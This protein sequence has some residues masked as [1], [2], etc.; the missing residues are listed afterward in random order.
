MTK[1]R[2]RWCSDSLT[3]LPGEFQVKSKQVP[4]SRCLPRWRPQNLNV[5]KYQNTKTAETLKPKN[6]TDGRAPQDLLK[7][8]PEGLIC[9]YFLSWQKVNCFF[10]LP[11]VRSSY[12]IK[13]PGNY[14]QTCQN[15]LKDFSQSFCDLVTCKLL[16]V[17]SHLKPWTGLVGTERNI[18]NQHFIL[19]TGKNC[20]WPSSGVENAMKAGGLFPAEFQAVSSTWN[21]QWI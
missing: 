12:C 14:A 21:Q 20:C 19:W 17:G 7:R 2:Q 8:Q 10:I 9:L 5:H 1:E 11:F 13:V 6:T 15:R 16:S 4:V 3:I 18:L